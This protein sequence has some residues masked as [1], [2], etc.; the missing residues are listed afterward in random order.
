MRTQADMDDKTTS[1]T[2]RTVI[3]AAGS[4]LALG[5][6]PGLASAG[7]KGKG[8]G[9]NGGGPPSDAKNS[10]PEGTVLLAKYEVEEGEFVF[11]EDSDFLETGD[12][13]EFTITD[14]K[15]GGEVL[16]FDFE[17]S[18]GAYDVHTI[19]VKT[20]AG[21]FQKSFE[22]EKKYRGSFDAKKF[23]TEDPVQ[24]VSN[25]L[26]CSKVFWQVD[27]GIREIPEPPNYSQ[28]DSILLL[29]AI[30]DSTG[31]RKNPSAG[32]TEG[33]YQLDEDTKITFDSKFDIPEE[34]GTANIHFSGNDEGKNIHLA[35]FERPG[36]FDTTSREGFTYQ[37]LFDSV[38]TTGASETLEVDLPMLKDYS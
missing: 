17:D 11:E 10:C 24:A 14:T 22:E 20:G 8:G 2:R 23:D 28:S 26:I 38:S 35:S 5:A 18:K 33:E 15:D 34:G 21:V 6:V 29:A 9:D 36:P 16:A 7:G 25:V 19:S 3:G 1:S 32:S 4:A 13:F 30:G 31:Q 37:D 12:V 27:L